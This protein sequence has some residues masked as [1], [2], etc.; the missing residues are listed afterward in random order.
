MKRKM[1]E[2]NEELCNGCGNCTTGCSEGALQIVNG[3]AKVVKEEFCDGFGDCI[4][5]CPTGALKIVERD[6]PEFDIKAA[7]EHLR[8]TQGEDAVKKMYEAQK[9]HEAK[10]AGHKNAAGGGHD[11]HHGHGGCPSAR[12]MQ[13]N[14]AAEAPVSE[15]SASGP[16]MKSQLAQ[17]PVQLHLVSPNHPAFKN[18]EL[19]VSADCVSHAFGDFHRKMLAGKALAIACPKL[20]DTD[21][22]VEKLTAII[23]ANN[24]KSVTCA[25][26]E[27]PCCGGLL[28]MVQTAVQNSGTNVPLKVIVIGVDGSIRES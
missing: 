6:A 18:A 28:R 26:M 16:E 7:E 24:M 10:E 4:G 5:H 12:F 15:S 1:I 9:V 25:I 14:K 22:Y 11:H 17:W 23:Q 27:V 3:K 8:K 13:F 2:I 19:L 21:G 20:D